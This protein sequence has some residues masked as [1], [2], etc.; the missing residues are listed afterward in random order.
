MMI[1]PTLKL[2]LCMLIKLVNDSLYPVC[3]LVLALITQSNSAWFSNFL[4]FHSNHH[5]ILDQHNMHDTHALRFY[6]V[7]ILHSML[8]N[9]FDAFSFNDVLSSLWHLC[10]RHKINNSRR[11]LRTTSNKHSHAMLLIINLI[12]GKKRHVEN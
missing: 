12:E 7:T 11:F 1:I 3:Y 10:V 6:I 5:A 9:M 8:I 2:W 4:T